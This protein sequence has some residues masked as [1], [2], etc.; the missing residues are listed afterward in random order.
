M[1]EG[2]E[3]FSGLSF[4][5][6]VTFPPII[7]NLGHQMFWPPP[8]F[9]HECF[10]CSCS[11]RNWWRGE[12]ED[13]Y[14]SPSLFRSGIIPIFG[15]ARA[16]LAPRSK[17]DFGPRKKSVCLY[18]PLLNGRRCHRLE[19]RCFYDSLLVTKEEKEIG[20]VAK[21]RKVYRVRA[22]KF[23]NL[24]LLSL[25]SGKFLA[26]KQ[27]TFTN[28]KVQCNYYNVVG[29]FSPFFEHPLRST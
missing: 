10:A 7:L 16:S 23:I 20:H 2:R 5:L 29:R 25:L 14:S 3:I 19:R 11:S 18:V 15:V 12:E 13:S 6:V 8:T 27:G 4:V 21:A 9:F 1:S 22:V 28:R 26:G 17:Q 24:R